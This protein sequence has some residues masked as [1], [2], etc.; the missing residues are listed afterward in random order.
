MARG[1]LAPK[2]ANR[3][4]LSR[5]GFNQRAGPTPG[6]VR[7]AATLHHLSAS[8]PATACSK[9]RQ[10]SRAVEITPTGSPDAGNPPGYHPPG[11]SSTP[12]KRVLRPS[13]G[14]LAKIPSPTNCGTSPCAERCEYCVDIGPCH[15]TKCRFAAPFERVFAWSRQGSKRNSIKLPRLGRTLGRE[16]LRYVS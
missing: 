12:T 16:E 4:L 8:G 9:R 1:C 7:S 11:L 5:K 13:S 14:P 15:A 2:A 3:N 10:K 6:G